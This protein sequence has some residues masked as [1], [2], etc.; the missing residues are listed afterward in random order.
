MKA[1]RE[2]KTYIARYRN[3]LKACHWDDIMVEIKLFTC[4]KW[5]KREKKPTKYDML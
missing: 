4:K 3:H 5:F 2:I 1:P